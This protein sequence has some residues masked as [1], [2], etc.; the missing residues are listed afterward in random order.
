MGCTM[1]CNPKN[2]SAE[3]QKEKKK[4]GGKIKEKKQNSCQ[5]L[6]GGLGAMEPM[7]RAL[8]KIN[9]EG[10]DVVKGGND[11]G[12]R[13]TSAVENTDTV[14]KATWGEVRLGERPPVG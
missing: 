1:K 8:I 6:K 4:G 2:N 11:R 5:K 12:K 10:S 9:E 3:T 14:R 13:G 7:W